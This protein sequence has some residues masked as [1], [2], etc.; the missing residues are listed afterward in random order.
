VSVCAAAGK[1]LMRN[2]NEAKEESLN[3]TS[4]S[5]SLYIIIITKQTETKTARKTS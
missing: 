2:V 5:T 1:L 3:A 4:T